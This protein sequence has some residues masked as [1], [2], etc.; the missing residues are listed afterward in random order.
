MKEVEYVMMNKKLIVEI[1][2]KRK[3]EKETKL[4]RKKETEK[5]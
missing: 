1:E 4:R 2:K 3:D 5:N